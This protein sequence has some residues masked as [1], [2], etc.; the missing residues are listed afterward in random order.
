MHTTDR[1]LARRAFAEAAGE[2]LIAAGLEKMA[3]DAALGHG[4]LS[5][6]E[7]HEERRQH[8]AVE[9]RRLNDF[10]DQLRPMEGVAA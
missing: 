1:E 7:R 8:L 10:A 9:A 5:R 3:R 2:R 6:A 4:D